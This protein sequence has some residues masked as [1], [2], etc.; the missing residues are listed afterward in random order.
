[1]SENL[2]RIRLRAFASLRR[3]DGRSNYPGNNYLPGRLMQPAENCPGIRSP[4]T[5]VRLC[6]QI[7]T[8]THT[9]TDKHPHVLAKGIS[10]TAVMSTS[11]CMYT[12]I[13]THDSVG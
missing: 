13:H 7:H 9:H 4:D 3:P 12:Y 8:H 5:L 2:H 1:M 6:T 10:M 11:V